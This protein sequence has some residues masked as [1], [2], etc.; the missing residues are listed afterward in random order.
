M[1]RAGAFVQKKEPA[2]H[3]LWLLEFQLENCAQV[4]VEVQRRISTLTLLLQEVAADY[5]MTGSAA[6]S[7]PLAFAALSALNAT[8]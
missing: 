5:A 1:P 3:R 6:A 4:R 2:E 8:R 7:P